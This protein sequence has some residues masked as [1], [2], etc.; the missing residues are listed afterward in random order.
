MAGK[1]AIMFDETDNV[2]SLEDI[3]AAYATGT[4]T[5]EVLKPDGSN[6]VAFGAAPTPIFGQDEGYAESWGG[7]ATGAKTWQTKVTLVTPT[8]E[9][10][11]KYLL[12]WHFH[13]MTNVSSK[14]VE[15]RVY[16]N[17]DSVVLTT[18]IHRR[19]DWTK[20]SSVYEFTPGSTQAYTFYIQYQKV[21]SGAAATAEI[22]QACLQIFKV[23]DP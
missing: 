22:R 20:Y 17:T 6:G 23:E 19:M 12:A 18:D 5:T 7:S 3:V 2:R 1:R 21:G 9:S 8:L 4:T 15:H 11:D 13:T 16:N 10:G 14:D